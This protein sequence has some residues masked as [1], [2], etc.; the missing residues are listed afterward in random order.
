[1]KREITTRIQINSYP[2]DIWKILVD[3]DSYS[4]WNPFIIAAKGKICEGQTINITIE[5]MKHK[6]FSFTPRIVE[7]IP[8]R[9]ITWQGKTLVKGLF[10]GQHGFELNDNKDGTTTLIQKEHFSGLLIPLCKRMIEEDTLR[11]FNLMNEALRIRTENIHN[12]KI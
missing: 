9:K 3:L 5:P 11:G 4:L 12:P 6:T 10:D 1:M 2:E 7:V 8:N